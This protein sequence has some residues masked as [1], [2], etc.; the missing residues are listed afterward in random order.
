MAQAFLSGGNP[1]TIGVNH[2]RRAV[3]TALT[4]VLNDANRV[5]DLFSYCEAFCTVEPKFLVN[6]FLLHLAPALAFYALLLY[7]GGGERRGDQPS[8]NATNAADA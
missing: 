8:L 5:H 1:P 6:R 4:D 7:V 3:Y 2:R